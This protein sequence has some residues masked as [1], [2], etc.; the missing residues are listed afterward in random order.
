MVRVPAAPRTH[1]ASTHRPPFRARAERR[2][3]DAIAA[4]GEATGAAMDAINGG[5]ATVWHNQQQLEA[6]ARLLHQQAQRLSKQSAQWAQSYQGFHQAL[7]DLGDVEN[8]AK[9]IESDMAFIHSSL[10][11]LHHGTAQRHAAEAAD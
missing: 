10:D 3:Q 8:W 2:K 9:A 7:K 1:C 5:A 4:V 6:E 11:A